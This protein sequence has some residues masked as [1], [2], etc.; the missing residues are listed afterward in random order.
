MYSIRLCEERLAVHPPTDTL[1]TSPSR[2]PGSTPLMADNLKDIPIGLD[3]GAELIAVL[4]AVGLWGITCVQTLFYFI[5][6]PRDALFMRVMVMW[7]WLADSVHQLLLV[8]GA[9]KGLITNFCDYRQVLQVNAVVVLLIQVKSYDTHV[10]VLVALPSQLFFINRIAKFSG[11]R[12]LLFALW[13]PAAVFELGG[14]IAFITFGTITPTSGELVSRT[15]T[16]IFITVQVT[17]AVVDISI[18]TGLICLLWRSREN[19]RYR[20]RTVIQRLLIVSLS[21][22]VWTALFAIFTVIT[23]LAFPDT[24]IYV[25]LYFPLCPLYCNTVLVNLNARQIL[26]KLDRRPIIGSITFCRDTES[27]VHTVASGQS[28]ILDHERHELS[29]GRAPRSRCPPVNHRYT[30]EAGVQTLLGVDKFA[31]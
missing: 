8:R 11:K 21:T 18:T 29:L 30:A 2:T 10:K 7:L 28:N 3:V 13:A 23:M 9:Y 22:G 26:A 1:P 6:F 14:A 12:W 19:A 4:F 27:T 24:Q 5:H 31:A 17:A 15:P 16:S 20:M 25:G